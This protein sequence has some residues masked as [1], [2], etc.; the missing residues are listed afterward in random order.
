MA[1]KY[2]ADT[3]AVLSKAKDKSDD[4]RVQLDVF[5][6][7]VLDVIKTRDRVCAATSMQSEINIVPEAMGQSMCSLAHHIV[8]WISQVIADGRDQGVMDFPG[9]PDDQAAL[10]Y[11]STQGAMQYGR[12]L[13]PDKARQVIKQIEEIMKPKN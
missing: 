8:A 6:Q 9:S 13:G 1:E 12:T 7:L 5:L 2:I 11:S 3:K 4:P 10:I